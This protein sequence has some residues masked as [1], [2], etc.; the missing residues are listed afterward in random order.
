VSIRLDESFDKDRV[1][2]FLDDV[3]SDEFDLKS[4]QANPLRTI[5]SL[6]IDISPDDRALL[7]DMSF[8]DLI[9]RRE[10]DPAIRSVAVAIAVIIIAWPRE[11]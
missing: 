7:G 8:T 2:S 11:K 9:G 5:N 1:S 10:G 3:L 4:A 6:G